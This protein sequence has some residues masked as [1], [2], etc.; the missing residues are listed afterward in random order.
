MTIGGDVAGIHAEAQINMVGDRFSGSGETDPMAK[1]TTT[2]IR[3][4]YQL[5]ETF[6]LKAR[7]ENAGN[8]KYE[9]V[10]GYGVAERATYFGVSA[11]F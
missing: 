8:S 3:L 4:A 10:S 1:Y 6:K 7:V 5:N 11:T 2:D 9:Q